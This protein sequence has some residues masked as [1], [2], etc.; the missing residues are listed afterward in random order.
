MEQKTN[1]VKCFLCKKNV[2]LSC[3]IVDKGT[4]FPEI[5]RKVRDRHEIEVCYKCVARK[6]SQP[7]ARAA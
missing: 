4:L 5:L 3:V 7:K 1:L 6:E 2:P